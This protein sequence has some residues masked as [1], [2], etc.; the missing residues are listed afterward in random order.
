MLPRIYRYFGQRRR[1]TQNGVSVIVVNFN[2]RELLPAVLGAVRHFSS[3]DTE[4]IVIDNASTDGSWEWLRSRPYGSRVHRLPFNLGH[5]RALDIGIALATRDTIVTLDSDAFPFSHVWLERLTQPLN[6]GMDAAGL[7]GRRDRLHPACAAYRRC[8]YYATG[9]SL[10]G[11]NPHFERGE[12]PEFGVNTWDTGELISEYFGPTRIRLF[13][14]KQTEYGGVTL[15]DAVYHHQASTTVV[16]DVGSGDVHDHYHAWRRAVAHY[17]EP[18]ADVHSGFRTL[19]A[20][21]ELGP[22]PVRESDGWLV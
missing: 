11:F 17:L 4:L 14:I 6:D 21:E 15:M 10:S 13:D 22:R 20:G 19:V 2:T 7:W 1:P 8:T 12:A 5:G 3:P 9:L 18:S 16:T